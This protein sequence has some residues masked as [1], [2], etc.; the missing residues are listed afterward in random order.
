MWTISPAVAKKEPIVRRCNNS[1]SIRCLELPCNMLTMAIPDVE[2]LAVRLFTVCFNGFASW[3]QCLL[4]KRWAVWGDYVGVDG[5]KLWIRLPMGTSYSL[6]LFR[7]F[8]CRMYRLSTIHF[9]TDR[10]TD[11]QTDG[12]SDGQ[13]TVSYYMVQYDRL[14]ML[15]FEP[16]AAYHFLFTSLV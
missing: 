16:T 2:I 1:K 13:T 12:R 11:R 10:Q 6:H 4:F 7:P 9:V 5:L 3:Y 14:K 15:T 8:C